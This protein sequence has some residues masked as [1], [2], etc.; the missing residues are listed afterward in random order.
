[1]TT[2]C[3]A[4][5]GVVPGITNRVKYGPTSESDAQCVLAGGA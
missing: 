5:G 4:N 2:F 3:D 1:M